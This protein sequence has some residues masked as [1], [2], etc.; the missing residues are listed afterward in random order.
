[1][2]KLL[3]L[4]RF[5][6]PNLTVISFGGGSS[7][8]TANLTPEQ[9]E[10]L[11]LQTQQLRDV[12]MPQYTQAV[13]GAQ[14]TYN[15]LSPYA[16]QAA[17]NTYNNAA[18][19]SNAQQGI[20]GELTNFGR[21]SSGAGYGGA[22]NVAD[23]MATGG[24]NLAVA[25]TQGLMNLFSPDYKNEQIQASLQPA[26]E[27]IRE[28]LAGQNTMYGGA[29]GLGSSRMA[30]A[31][32]NLSQ[33]G[34]QRLQSSAAQTSAAIEAQRQQAATTMLG[35]GA[36]AL[37]QSGGLYGNLL[38]SGLGSATAGGALLG[39]SVD[40]SGKAIT[41]AQSPMDLYNKYASVVF[42]VPQASTTPNFAG[43]QGSTSSGSGFNFGIGQGSDISIK[44]NI[45]KIG[46][47]KNGINLYKFE[48]KDQ[49]KDTWGHGQQ[50][51]VM[52]QE[53]EK[54]IPEA[55]STHKDGYKLVNY[56]MVM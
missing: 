44:E 46:S 37:S 7:S 48:Y 1:M 40:T 53:V 14:S 5:F 38:T 51:G 39:Q 55:V 29:G 3:K 8:T 33:L 9:K 52:A 15:Q 54:V 34:Q 13:Q 47:L 19:M 10:L 43:T 35:T 25:G 28:Q 36:Q 30:L 12:F 45:Q 31:D 17:L 4:Y 21:L 2:F 16:N 26:R 6:V 56:S 50:V 23:V 41:A 11:Q 49:Y 27:A 18:S 20:G 24:Q 32:R 42:G 22:K